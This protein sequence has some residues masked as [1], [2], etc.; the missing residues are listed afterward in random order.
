[1]NKKAFTI[2]ELVVVFGIVFLVVLLLYPFVRRIHGRADKVVCA[3]NLRRI[4]K[5][6]YVYAKEHQGKF[7]E[8]LKTLYDEQYLA[9]IR[10]ADC[11]ATRCRGTLEDP[12]YVYVSGLSVKD[13]SKHDL[14]RD[15]SGNHPTD[16]KNVL[17]VNGIVMWK[18]PGV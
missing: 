9:D 15:K 11:P 18:E 7:P 10:Y 6:M 2:G 16:G 17:C 14:V 3:N 4:G 12:D 1:M 8:D 5:A 13:P